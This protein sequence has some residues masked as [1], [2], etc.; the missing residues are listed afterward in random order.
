MAITSQTF[1]T[2]GNWQAPAGVNGVIVEC[3]GGGAGGSNNGSATARPGGGGGGGGYSKTNV[4]RVV[5]G[6]TYTV[7]VGAQVNAGAVGN[8]SSFTGEDGTA[9]YAVG[10]GTTTTRTGG[11]GSGTAAPAVGDVKYGGGAGGTAANSNNY[12]GG[13]GGEG[14]RDG[15]DRREWQFQQHRDGWRGWHRWRRRG[16]RQ[17][18]RQQR[19]GCQRQRAGRRR[20]WRRWE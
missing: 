8:P 3:W 9:C 13:G 12:G 19:G 11:I 15:C 10:G 2:T 4:V 6:K 5:P 16:W 17:G 20:G 1:A 14:A 7:T 18:R